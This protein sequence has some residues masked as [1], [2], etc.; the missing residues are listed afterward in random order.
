MCLKYSYFL[1][2]NDKFKIKLEID[3]KKYFFY[4]LVKSDV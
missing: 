2:R 4:D 3:R 1:N